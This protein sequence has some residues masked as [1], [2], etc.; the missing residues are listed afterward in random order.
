MLQVIV[1]IWNYSLIEKKGREIHAGSEN[2]FYHLIGAAAFSHFIPVTTASLPSA[3][4][5]L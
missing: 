4:L 2:Y 3:G 1:R 5:F